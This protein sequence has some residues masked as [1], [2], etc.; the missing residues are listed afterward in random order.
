MTGLAIDLTPGKIYVFAPIAARTMAGVRAID[1]F[2]Q[3]RCEIVCTAEEVMTH[4]Q[5]VCYRILTGPHTG[6]TVVCTLNYFLAFLP[7]E[8]PVIAEPPA[9]ASK[10][11]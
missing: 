10:P 3:D 4:R 5:M 8:A 1:R 7:V 2:P 9:P 6:R 11:W